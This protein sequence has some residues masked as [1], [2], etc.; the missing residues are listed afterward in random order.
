MSSVALNPPAGEVT[1]PRVQAILGSV[2]KDLTQGS[3]SDLHSTSCLHRSSP[4]RRSRV[5]GAYGAH[6]AFVLIAGHPHH[7]TGKAFG[8]A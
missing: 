4:S 5:G 1:C 3:A 8:G 6:K 7:R 2:G